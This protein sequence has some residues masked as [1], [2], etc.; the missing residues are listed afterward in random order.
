MT[1]MDWSD[2][3]AGRRRASAHARVAPPRRPGRGEVDACVAIHAVTV[4]RGGRDGDVFSG[5]FPSPAGEAGAQ[6]HLEHR[7][8]ARL[9]ADAIVAASDRAR[10]AAELQVVDAELGE[11]QRLLAAAEDGVGDLPLLRCRPQP[12]RRLLLAVW[13]AADGRHGP[14]GLV[15]GR[16]RRRLCRGVRASGF[17]RASAPAA[18][19]A[20]PRRRLCSL[21]LRWWSRWA[22][23]G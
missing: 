6:D 23:R 11:L 12:R 5:A 2:A 22:L 21:R 19:R 15:V 8:P 3:P 14:E 10:K 9:T 13:S 4:A 7:H 16:P 17:A 18:L 20:R 1:A